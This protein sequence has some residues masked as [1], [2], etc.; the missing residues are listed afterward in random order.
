MRPTNHSDTMDPETSSQELRAA[1]SP[2]V[3]A[4][5]AARGGSP[6]FGEER[7]VMQ[8]FFVPRRIAFASSPR[9]L[10]PPLRPSLAR[11][12]KMRLYLP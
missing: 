11:Q 12:P 1:R 3:A 8:C 9:S 10:R 7:L 6:R 4:W 5:V 2:I